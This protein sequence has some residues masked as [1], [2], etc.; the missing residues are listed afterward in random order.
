[1][2]DDPSATS[3]PPEGSSGP[4]AN[5][6]PGGRGRERRRAGPRTGSFPNALKVVV[7]LGV[8]AVLVG[9]AA[10]VLDSRARDA[11]DGS[12][13]GLPA[14]RIHRTRPS[15]QAFVMPTTASSSS[16]SVAAWLPSTATTT[17]VRTCTSPVAQPGQRPCSAI[18]APWA[19][20][21][22]R[23]GPSPVTDL[24]RSPGRTRSTS[25]ATGDDLACCGVGGNVLL[26]GLGDC[27]FERA[28]ETL[29]LRRRRRLDRRLQRDVGG[30]RGPP[31]AR[32]RGLPR[33]RA[34]NPIG[35]TSCA[36]SQLSGPTPDGTAY[37]RADRRCSPGWCT[38]SMLFS[39]WDRS[40]RRDLRVSND[41]HYDPT[42]RSSSGAIAP[43]EP[44]Q[45][46]TRDEGWA[47][48]RD[49]AWASPAR[50]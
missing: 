20:R 28:N 40:G 38:L 36:D 47:R 49:R 5:V 33:A 30:R 6:G 43:G 9:G 31:D 39:D 37:G 23:A 14:P 48:L 10:F 50:T 13:T 4:D 21:C 34:R 27:R 11:A 46:Y 24:T 12:P 7:A 32:V 16:S 1:M 29:G 41:R 2:S 19:A 42:A 35:T 44:P 8:A 45:L 3:A 15:R 25:T 17:G 18:G 22:V 26:R